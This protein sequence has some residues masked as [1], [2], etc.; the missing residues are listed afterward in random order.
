MV[1]FIISSS[2][3]KTKTTG[4]LINNYQGTQALLS[5]VTIILQHERAVSLVK[6]H[7]ISASYCTLVV[8]PP[9]RNAHLHLWPYDDII[10]FVYIAQSQKR[11]K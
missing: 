10:V 2:R 8:S 11:R 7:K 6:I 9:H 3:R 5:K 1:D 4:C